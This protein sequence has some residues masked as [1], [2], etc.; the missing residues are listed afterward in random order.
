MGSISLREWVIL[1][2]VRPIKMHWESVLRQFTHQKINNG[3]IKTVGDRLQCSKKTGWCLY[4]IVPRE[5]FA[6]CDSAFCQ[7][8]LTT[9]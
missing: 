8:S 2:V 7:N 3:D 4:Y 9:C 1:G 5:K 6:A